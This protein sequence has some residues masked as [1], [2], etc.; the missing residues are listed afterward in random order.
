MLRKRSCR[1]WIKHMG[2]PS[3][4]KVLGCWPYLRNSKEVKLEQNKEGIINEIREIMGEGQMSQGPWSHCKA[5]SYF[6]IGDGKPKE[7]LRKA[8]KRGT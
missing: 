3:G 1:Q 7:G 8:H 6:T 2:W 5:F 4:S